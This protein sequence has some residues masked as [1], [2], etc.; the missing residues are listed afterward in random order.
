MGADSKVDEATDVDFGVVVASCH[1][2]LVYSSLRCTLQLLTVVSGTVVGVD[3]G[4]DVSFSVAI[5]VGL[6]V[7]AGSAVVVSAGVVSGAFNSLGAKS[8]R[9]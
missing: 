5:V 8:M 6:V 2:T 3:W 7:V 9:R 1:H 4:A